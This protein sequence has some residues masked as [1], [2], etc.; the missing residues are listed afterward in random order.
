MFGAA[1]SGGP[2]GAWVRLGIW[3]YL[4]N[5]ASFRETQVQAS[6]HRG[7]V[8]A[9]CLIAAYPATCRESSFR[10]NADPY[11]IARCITCFITPADDRKPLRIRADVCIGYAR[12]L[13]SGGLWQVLRVAQ[14]A[15]QS[16]CARF[17]RSLAPGDHPA[18]NAAPADQAGN[19][20]EAR[21]TTNRRNWVRFGKTE[22]AREN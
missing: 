12:V 22:V 7:F 3:R 16:L 9:G 6:S 17:Q 1:K 18:Q 14:S 2:Y 21:E 19:F 11:Q 8:W 13:Q 4:M 20:D 15:L 5:L 10:E